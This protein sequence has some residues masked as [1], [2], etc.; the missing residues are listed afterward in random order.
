MK[1]I[2]PEGGRGGE[3]G[4][5]VGPVVCIYIYVWR[6]SVCRSGATATGDTPAE[7]VDPSGWPAA[8]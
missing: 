6:L 1:L 7:M 5:G 8:L 3:G 4:G 2:S